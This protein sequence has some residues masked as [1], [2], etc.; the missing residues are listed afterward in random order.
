M[1]GWRA[2]IL[3]GTIVLVVACAKMPP[4]A[5][6]PLVQ[7]RQNATQ[8]APIGEG[9][10]Q[11]FTKERITLT[12]GDH[13]QLIGS[14]YDAPGDGVILLH[15]FQRNRESWDPFAKELQQRGLAAIAIDLRG[16]GESEGSLQ[17]FSDQDFQ[18]MLQDAEAAATFLQKREKRVGAIVGAS[19]G[20]NT[21]LRYS[22]VH[23]TPAVLLSPGLTYHGIDI[24][25]TTSNAPTLIVAAK[26]DDYAYSSSVELERNNLFG[27]H[28][29]LVVKGSQHGTDMLSEPGVAEAMLDFLQNE[30]K[31]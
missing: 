8:A 2:A 20:A 6:V 23:K 4:S 29:L 11:G 1:M 22:S 12:T 25:D 15:Q 14:Y 28:R 17:A 26:G 9:M 21:A 16:H 31:R 24:N 13:V 30:T 10:E 19:I 27:E 7:E 3:L 18:A 5:N